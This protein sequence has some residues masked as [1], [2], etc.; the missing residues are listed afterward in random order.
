MRIA[1]RF[2]LGL[3]LVC[4]LGLHAADGP[5]VLFFNKSAGFEH[6]VIKVE[7]DKPNHVETIIRPLVEKMNGTLV[8]TKDGAAINKDNLKN[9]DVVVFYTTEDLCNSETGDKT[10]GVGPN[11]M[12]ELLDWVNEGGGL[13]G[14]HCA[15]DTW[16]RAR[17]QFSPESPYLDMLGGEFRGHGA[18]FE[19]TLRVVDA[20]HPTMPHIKDGWTVNDEWY[21]FTEFQHENMHVLALLDPG[22]ER[23][24]QEKYA[25]PNYPVIW[26]STPGKGRVFYNAMGH[27][28]DVWENEIFQHAY[29]DAIQWASGKGE[30]AATPNF[31]DVVPAELDAVT[32]TARE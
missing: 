23:S 8:A 14:Y 17:N 16:H 2:M 6:S 11:G 21:L 28:E 13:V 4:A 3:T 25:L 30:A 12:M 9:F 29:V 19:G 5:R 32:G 24:K 26:C 20:N 7:N 31:A 27:R 18:Q 10:P 1:Y 15:S 22:E